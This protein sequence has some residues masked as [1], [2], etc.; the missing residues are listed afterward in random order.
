MMSGFGELPLTQKG[1]RVG[2]G[3]SQSMHFPRAILVMSFVPR[4]AACRG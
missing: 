2:L 1:I 3:M 4:V